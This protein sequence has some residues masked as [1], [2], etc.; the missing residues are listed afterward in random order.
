MQFLVIAYDARDEGAA[1]RRL[2]AREAHLAH[3]ADFKERGH[4]KMGAAILDDAGAM[5]G[6]CV[7][8][9]FPSR[10]ALDAWLAEDPYITQ[11]VWHDVYVQDCRIAPAFA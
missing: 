9:D 7:I 8:A 11:D 2:A 1:A 10:A 6:S 3:V 5:V 4:V